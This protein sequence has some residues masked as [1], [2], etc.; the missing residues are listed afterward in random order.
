[1]FVE[2][3][4]ALPTPQRKTRS[5]VSPTPYVFTFLLYL[6]MQVHRPYDKDLMHSGRRAYSQMASTEENWGP[7]KCNYEA[8]SMILDT[9]LTHKTLLVFSYQAKSKRSL[10]FAEAIAIQDIG[11]KSL[12]T[13]GNAGQP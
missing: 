2:T 3:T 9:L 5:L 7:K 1:M 11:P 4:N 6:W 8:L 12:H 13:K 10:G